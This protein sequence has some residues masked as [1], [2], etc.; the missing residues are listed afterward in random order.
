MRILLAQPLGY[1]YATGGAHKANR[2]LME[3]LAKR[4]HHCRALTAYRSAESVQTREQFL[5]SLAKR[6]VSLSSSSPEADVFSLEGVEVHVSR[7]YLH[8]CSRLSDH[9][10]EFK[11]DWVLVSED[12]ASVMLGA[13]LEAAPARVVYIAHSPSTLPFGLDS[14]AAD[15]DKTILLNKCAGIITVSNYMQQYIERWSGIASAAIKFPVYG[16]EPFPRFGSFESGFVTMVNPC[17]IKGQT[18]FLELAR[19]FPDVE[20]AAVPTWGALNKDLELIKDLPNVRIIQPSERVDDILS[21]TRILLAPSL[22]GE[23]YGQIVTEAMLR[24]IPVLASDSGGLLEAKLGTDYILPVRCIEGYE[25]VLDE[26]KRTV[27]VPL[28]PEQDVDPWE[29]ALREV[30]T[31][32]ATYERVS[33]QSREAATHFVNGLGFRP[34]EQ[35]LEGLATEREKPEGQ[36]TDASKDGEFAGAM[37]EMS[38]EKRALIA[39]RLKGRLE[40]VLNKRRTSSENSFDRSGSKVS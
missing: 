37:S 23:A 17:V 4:G 24:A 27:Y 14:F 30:L 21:Q 40:E 35:Y 7:D 31:E 28:V 6:G 19:R 26:L 25:P 34:F 33:E 3:G 15:P 18:I 8:Q 22:W 10:R 12:T 39:R 2:M 13:A 38:V 5:S 11:P 9:V 20:F 29:A 32:R 1:L 16:T 36:E